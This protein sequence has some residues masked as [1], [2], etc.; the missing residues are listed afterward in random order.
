MSFQFIQDMYKP[1]KEMMYHKHDNR[2]WKTVIGFD[3]VSQWLMYRPRYVSGQWD[4]NN[5]RVEKPRMKWYIFNWRTRDKFY[6]FI[7]GNGEVPVS[8]TKKNFLW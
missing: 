1:I 8:D 5:I 4:V 3:S 6:G 2:K 7:Q